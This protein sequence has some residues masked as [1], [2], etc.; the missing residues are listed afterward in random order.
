MFECLNKP[1]T[2]REFGDLIGIAKQNVSKAFLAGALPP[3]GT[4]RDWLL[5]YCDRLRGVA[6]VRGGDDQ[7]ALTR[8]RTELALT[9][10]EG[11]RRALLREADRLAEVGWVREALDG[12][13]S[14][15]LASLAKAEERMAA[16]LASR[17]VEDVGFIREA[18]RAV[19]EE[20][21]TRPAPL[22][23][24]REEPAP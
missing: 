17:G 2:Q 14:V 21:A 22:Q 18:L 5:A 11:K 8:A 23:R 6:D 7:R 15:G 19:T 24:T 9:D 10:A 12:W 3:G 13:E 4:L 16:E 20:L 1:A